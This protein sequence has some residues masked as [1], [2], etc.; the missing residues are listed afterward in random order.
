MSE[1]ESKDLGTVAIRG[2][3]GAGELGIAFM[4]VG[5]LLA[6]VRIAGVGL[7]AAALSYAGV[8]RARAEDSDAIEEKPAP[9]PANVVSIRSRRRRPILSWPWSRPEEEEKAPPPVRSLRYKYHR[10]FA[11]LSLLWVG[12]AVLLQAGAIR[13]ALL[14]ESHRIQSNA[15]SSERMLADPF[16]GMRVQQEMTRV[17]ESTLE[18]PHLVIQPFDENGGRLPPAP[19]A[20]RTPAAKI[21]KLADGPCVH[22]P[23]ILDDATVASLLERGAAGHRTGGMDVD[24]VE[25]EARKAAFFQ[26][27]AV[28]ASIHGQNTPRYCLAHAFDGNHIISTLLRAL[29]PP[30][31]GHALLFGVFLVFPWATRRLSASLGVGHG[32]EAQ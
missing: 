21:V 29:V 8:L 19:R 3:L 22:F 31:V 13:S 28:L 10:A 14:A 17:A 7:I 25:M 4:L 11:V 15:A 5:I 23:G 16:K 27:E 9:L 2:A 24:A 18:P 30:L 12:H 1:T 6:D 32:G 20:G 26:S